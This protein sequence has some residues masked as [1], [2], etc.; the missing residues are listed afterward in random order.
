MPGMTGEGQSTL[1]AGSPGGCPRRWPWAAGEMEGC[2]SP[3]G[4]GHRLLAKGKASP[5]ELK[6]KAR[7]KQKVE[8]FQ[9]QTC[10][11]LTNFFCL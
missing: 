3:P 1:G 4:L 11:C 6:G 7:R 10:V 9:Y 2:C 5:E 8:S